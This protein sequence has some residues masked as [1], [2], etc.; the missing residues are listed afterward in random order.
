MASIIKS[1][2]AKLG[3]D[4]CINPV[5]DNVRMCPREKDNPFSFIGKQSEYMGHHC[6]HDAAGTLQIKASLDSNPSV[7]VHEVNATRCQV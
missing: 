3:N 6:Y 4:S 2:A 5:E 7:E 1:E